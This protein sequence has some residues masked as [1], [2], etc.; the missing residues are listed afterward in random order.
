MLKF[1]SIK[2]SSMVFGA[3]VFL[4]LTIN[5]ASLQ[6]TEP[7]GKGEKDRSL[8]TVVMKH[9]YDPSYKLNLE[10]LEKLPR[11]LT[12][13][14]RIDFKKLFS[15]PENPRQKMPAIALAILAGDEMRV[16]EF[17][18]GS[19]ECRAASSQEGDLHTSKAINPNAT[20][21]YVKYDMINITE[22]EPYGVAYYSLVHLALHPDIAIL[23]I[24]ANG[25]PFGPSYLPDLNTISLNSRFAVLDA[26]AAAGA[27]FNC[28]PSKYLSSEIGTDERVFDKGP[29]GAIR[30]F[31]GF[32]QNTELSRQLMARA[33][34]YGADIEQNVYIRSPG[35][36]PEDTDKFR[37]DLLKEVFHQIVE[38]KI[39]T[40]N[41]HLSGCVKRE[42]EKIKDNEIQAIA[43]RL[44]ILKKEKSLMPLTDGGFGTEEEQA[45]EVDD[46]TRRLERTQIF[47]YL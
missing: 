34:L 11:T 40:E 12:K 13:K 8:Y 37:A 36:L 17:L 9:V 44:Q 16:K 20:S 6:A 25:T 15:D 5:N 22:S 46:L 21:L 45:K 2:N 30:S 19:G 41:I 42:L 10:Y 24:G 39:Q 29:L 43:S 47:A 3:M 27:D 35:E 18:A 32:F 38:R 1:I 31:S 23:G 4:S 33:V 28:V 26:L 14:D 7:D